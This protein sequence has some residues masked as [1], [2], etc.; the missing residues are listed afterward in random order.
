MNTKQIQKIISKG[1]GINTE[2]RTAK[3]KLNKDA[4]VSIC[5]FLNRSG[6]YLILGISDDGK[7]TGVDVVQTFL[8]DIVT[9]S[10]NS[11]QLQIKCGIAHYNEVEKV[12]YKVVSKVGQL[13]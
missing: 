9:Q 1:E 2:F 4:F 7:V 10:N 5:A 8:Y 11:E 12:E 6:G 13:N 3:N